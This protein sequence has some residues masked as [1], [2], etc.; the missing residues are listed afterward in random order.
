MYLRLLLFVLFQLTIPSIH[1]QIVNISADYVNLLHNI[2]QLDDF[3]ARFNGEQD[4]YFLKRLKQKQAYP[5]ETID[6]EMLITSLF[7]YSDSSTIDEKIIADFV[8]DVTIHCPEKL[9]YN[10]TD[11]YANA[12]TIFQYQEDRIIV[13]FTL[14]YTIDDF[15]KG[16][17]W[18]IVALSSCFFQEENQ[19]KSNCSL[20]PPIIKAISP[21]SNEIFFSNLNKYF[22]KKEYLACYFRNPTQESSKKIIH[23]LCA[24][25]LKF[26]QVKEICYHFI[27]FENWIFELKY[28]NS[29][30]QYPRNSGWLITALQKAEK[31]EKLLYKKQIL[32]LL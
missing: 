22:N 32:S 14:Q 31:H 25:Q 7:H 4:G 17:S 15:T 16:A 20:R 28:I 26:I 29:N 8:A 11:W 3:F 1:G 24:D 23:A 2:S 6:R 5:I 21:K 9:F 18:E 10:S 13:D 12:E 27:Q 19:Q 30:P